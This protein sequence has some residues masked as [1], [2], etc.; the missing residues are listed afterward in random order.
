M[1]KKLLTQKQVCEYLNISRSTALRWESEGIL[2][3]IKTS[4]G[5]RR[6]K[7]EELD[8]W[9]GKTDINVNSRNCLI[10][11]RVSTKKQQEGGRKVEETIL[12]LEKEDEENENNG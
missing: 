7:I 10:Y 12:C 5:H 6:Y 9:M 8:S 2:N 4:G 3:P 11:A 1:S